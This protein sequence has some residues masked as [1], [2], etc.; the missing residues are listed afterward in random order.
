M[1]GGSGPRD[2]GKK[3]GVF[4]CTSNADGHVMLSSE[5]GDIAL[6]LPDEDAAYFVVG[7]SYAIDAK[8]P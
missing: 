7:Q 6:V 4:Q 5:L 8:K 3:I 2:G 1:G